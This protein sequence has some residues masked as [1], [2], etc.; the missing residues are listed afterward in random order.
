MAQRTR[1]GGHDILFNNKNKIKQSMVPDGGLF[2]EHIVVLHFFFF[3]SF[4]LPNFLN[5][6]RIHNSTD[7]VK[8]YEKSLEPF[9]RKVP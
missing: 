9:L 5:I 8:F 1:N 4:L 7:F 6:A 3:L 2:Y